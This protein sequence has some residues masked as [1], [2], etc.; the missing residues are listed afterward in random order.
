MYPVTFQIGWQHEVQYLSAGNFQ[1]LFEFIGLVGGLESGRFIP[2]V[3]VLNGFRF[4]KKGWEFALGPSMR[5]VKKA[6]GYYDD[7]GK[8][9]LESE[10]EGD[11]NTNTYPIVSRLDSRGQTALPTY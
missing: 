11:P 4:G 1:G 7:A 2:S 5:V 3:T 9:H 8:W 10:W 6:D